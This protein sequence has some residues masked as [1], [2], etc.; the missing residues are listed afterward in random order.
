[1]HLTTNE[2]ESASTLKEHYFIYRLMISTGEMY[3]YILK[4]PVSM[5]KNDKITMIPR[6]GADLGFSEDVCEKV[7]LKIWQQ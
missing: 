4:D 3:L 1:M 2:W 7:R 6:D 5:Y